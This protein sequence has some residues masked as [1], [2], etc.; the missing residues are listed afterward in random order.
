[1]E[2]LFFMPESEGQEFVISRYRKPRQNLGTT[3]AK[4][5][6][7]AGL[8][9]IVRPFD[10]MRASRSNEVYNR[11]GVTKESEWIGHSAKIRKDHYGMITDDDYEIASTWSISVDT[12]KKRIFP[13]IESKRQQITHRKELEIIGQSGH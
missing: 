12:D 7:R 4:I 3:F 9:P 1:M 8:S 11:F 10:N 5:V 13:A 2:T 6:K